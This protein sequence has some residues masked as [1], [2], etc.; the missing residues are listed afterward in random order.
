MCDMA[1]VETVDYN[2]QVKP[3]LKMMTE[4]IIENFKPTRIMLFG[5]YARGTPDYHSDVDLMVVMED[6]TNEYETA[7]KILEL[8]ADSP[9]A[10]DVIVTTPD[11]IKETG[12]VCGHAIYYALRE[13]VVLYER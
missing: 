10:K 6:G 11:E 4:R 7:V 12:H 2:E 1:K 8:L 13:G 3:V 5:S 9:V